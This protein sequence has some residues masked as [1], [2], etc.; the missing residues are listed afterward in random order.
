MMKNIHCIAVALGSAAVLTQAPAFAETRVGADLGLDGGY[1][2]NAFSAAGGSTG[3]A[4]VTASFRPFVDLISPG[5]STRI[6]G[7]VS[8]TE[9]SRLYDGQ[10]DF[11]G[12]LATQQRMGPRTSLSGNANY[13]SRVVNALYPIYN[14]I[15]P[16]PDNPDLPVIIDPATGGT[17]ARRTRML[18]GGLQL[19]QQVSARDSL[20]FQ[21]NGSM[22][23]YGKQDA[24]TLVPQSDYDMFGGGIG[25][26]R[27]ISATTAVGVA[28]NASRMHYK[29]SGFGNTTT[30]SP[31]LTLQTKLSPTVTLSAD[32]GVTFA[33]TDLAGGASRK[34]T[35]PSGSINLC[36]QRGERSSFCLSGAHS[37]SPSG[38]AGVSRQTSVGASYSY[39]LDPRSRI[40]AGGSY[41]RQSGISGISNSGTYD[42][43]QASLGYSRQVSRRLSAVASV[44]YA[45]SFNAIAARK[46]NFYGSVGLRYR[47]GDIR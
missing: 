15:L 26:Q 35:S 25:Y 10:T 27:S 44:S 40:T 13:T 34:T 21:V 1:A 19:H 14:P 8:R 39:A 32:A 42:Y 16:G 5:G 45:D 6:G 18:S 38:F 37:I 41:A 20:T 47:I 2:T 33:D 28:V 3:S 43:A 9:Y 36:K 12:M 46:A 29:A 30:I 4:T 31:A 24:N 11:G 22:L 23:R 17:F 7:D